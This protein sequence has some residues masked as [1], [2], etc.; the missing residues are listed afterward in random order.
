M[1]GLSFESQSQA[2][3]FPHCA[4]LLDRPGNVAQTAT[5]TGIGLFAPALASSH[6]FRD[7]PLNVSVALEAD[8]FSNSLAVIAEAIAKRDWV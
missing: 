8:V 3:L 5:T 6:A 2:A 1:V 4:S 7:D